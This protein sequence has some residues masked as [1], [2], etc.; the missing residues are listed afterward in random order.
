MREK[1]SLEIIGIQQ[2][3]DATGNMTVKVGEKEYNT[4]LEN[5]T[6][7]V[8][9]DDLAP[10][11]YSATVIYSGDDNYAG[12]EIAADFTVEKTSIP[13]DSSVLSVTNSSKPTFT[14]SLPERV[15]GNLTV[16]VGNNTYNAALVNGRAT[17]TVDDL[18]VGDYDA[19]VEYS[20]DENYTKSETDAKF[21]VTKVQYSSDEAFNINLADDSTIPT[22]TVKLPSDAT[23]IF[24]VNVDGKEYS[25]A[26][27]KGSA[28][29]T[30]DN[31]AP[32]NHNIVVSYSGDGNYSKITQTTTITIAT[33]VLSMN[34]NI[35]VVYSANAI[36]KVRITVN[37]KAVV[38]EKVTI[39]F[40]GKSYDVITDN[41]GYATL[42]IKTNI[43]V[44]SYIITAEYNGIKVS[45]KLT[46]KHLIK[47]KN[48]K[49]KKSKKVVKI[50]VKT[51]KVN[52]KFLKGKK[53][54]LRLKG[55]TLKA[56]INKKGI[57]T[58]KVK[59]NILKKLKFG[60]K[61]KY[62]VTYG[63]DKVTKK[64]KVRR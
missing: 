47:A 2:F 12:D 62:T 33:P 58:F 44:K 46:V 17:V 51:N 20:G 15:T 11:N 8:T 23:G 63:K 3:E 52:G 32:G 31:L 18:A 49:I 21:S 50:K 25:K 57:A 16:K 41:D 37:G 64:I 10:A 36:Y 59:K 9:V 19:V 4:T 13:L 27:S 45:N 28:T 24:T 14:I 56:K 42:N 48:L 30:L 53:L 54:K 34:K 60:K 7:T 61:Y 5:G 1:H 38:G 35:N 55:K 26:L 22:F 6:A 29:I 43:K 40:N 39:T